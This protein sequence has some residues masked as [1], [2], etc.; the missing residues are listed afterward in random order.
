MPQIP[1]ETFD[2][3]YDRYNSMVYD[4]ANQLTSSKRHVEQIL[5]SVFRKAHDQN[6]MEKTFPSPCITLIK[7]VLA[8]AHAVINQ[9][10]GEPNFKLNQLKHTPLLQHLLYDHTSIETYCDERGITKEQAGKHLRAEITSLGELLSKSNVR[11]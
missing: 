4:M 8:T 6:I 1:K 2:K 3:L 7:I 5:V 9:G 10:I 11:I